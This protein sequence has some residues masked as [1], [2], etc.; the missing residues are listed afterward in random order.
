MRKFLFCLSVGLCFIAQAQINSDSVIMTVAGKPIALDEFLF[1]AQK[2]GQ[3]DFSDEKS[4]TEYIEL[5]KNFKLKVADAVSLG[6]DK[7]KEFQS[8]IEEYEAL[9][10]DSYLTDKAAEEAFAKMIYDRGDYLLD[11]S[12][13]LFRLPQKALI[14]DTITIYEEALAVY[15]Q[16]KKNGDIDT[17]GQKIG[18]ESAGS[19]VYE[20]IYSVQ[21]MQTEKAFEDAIYSMREGDISLPVRT[22]YGYHIIRLNKRKP[23][24]GS[25]RVAHIMFGF[26]EQT[27]REQKAKLFV[28][29]QNILKQLR[30]GRDF[31]ELAMINST[32]ESSRKDGGLLSV[33][34]QG[35]MELPF[36]EAAFALVNPGDFSDIFETSQGYHILRLMER[37][38]RPSFDSQK[39]NLISLMKKTDYNFELCRK[40]D[41]KMR[42]DN[43]FNYFPEAYSELE[44]LCNDYFPSDRRFYE[45]GREKKNPLIEINGKKISQNEFIDY[46]QRFPY[47]SKNFAGDYLW[48]EFDFYVRDLLITETRNSIEIKYPEYNYLLQEYRD[49]TLLFEVSALKLWN[50][51]VNEQKTLENEWIMELNKEYPVEI[52][53]GLLQKMTK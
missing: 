18:H 41:E 19:I 30:D 15:N 28:D 21:P 29:A 39:N 10:M 2:N 14:K 12:H 25:V 36:E 6:L 8:D 47:S 22:N 27:T 13:I 20:R 35:Q 24:L 50:K 9:L 3:L 5:F 48:E 42:K 26:T 33:F 49:G 17:V 7:S 40:A 43:K 23:N 53:W 45:I 31:T 46:I 32:D 52:N 44:K 51:P 37:K 34:T 11:V 1:I 16:L 4:V 38:S